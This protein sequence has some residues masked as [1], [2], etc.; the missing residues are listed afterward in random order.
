MRISLCLSI[1]LIYRL[2]KINKKQVCPMIL[3]NPYCCELNKY[4][5]SFL[6]FKDSKTQTHLR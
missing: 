3:E 4:M 5:T 1:K 6:E 2:T